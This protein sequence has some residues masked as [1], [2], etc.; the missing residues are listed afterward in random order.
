V[1][2]EIENH[3]APGEALQAVKEQLRLIPNRGIGYGLLRYLSEQSEI[4]Q[5][6][7]LLPQP[8]VSFNYLGQIDGSF[9]PTSMFGLA[10]ES[11]GSP[12]SLEDNRAY[13][14]EIDGLIADGQLQMVWKYSAQ[15]YKRSTINSLAQ[16]FAEK[17]RSLIIHC[18]SSEAGGYTPSDFP[19]VNLSQEE[20]D[21]ALGKVEFT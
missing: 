18:Q 3:A 17:L 7:Q 9:S 8:E 5:Q 20:L 2:L 14:L 4:I 19:L 10:E 12:Y 1:F 11:T 21:A 6:L 15:M 16:S 13:L